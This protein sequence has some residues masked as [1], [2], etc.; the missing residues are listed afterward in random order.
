MT[1]QEIK[2]SGVEVGSEGRVAERIES[3]IEVGT[4]C[5]VV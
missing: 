3:A 2:K 4:G 1:Y 5:W